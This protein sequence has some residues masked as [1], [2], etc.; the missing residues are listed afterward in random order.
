MDNGEIKKF[1][2]NLC[3]PHKPFKTNQLTTY[4]TGDSPAAIGVIGVKQVHVNSPNVEGTVFQTFLNYKQRSC[5]QFITNEQVKLISFI[6]EGVDFTLG[7]RYAPLNKIEIKINETLCICI[8][9]SNIPISFLRGRARTEYYIRTASPVKFVNTFNVLQDTDVFNMYIGTTTYIK[10]IKEN[11]RSTMYRTWL[12]AEQYYLLQC[13]ILEFAA[14]RTPNYPDTVPWAYRSTR[15]C[16]T[17]QNVVGHWKG[18]VRK[19]QLM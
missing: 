1:P 18:K 16:N 6:W 19:S 12:Q 5:I 17:R 2:N 13:R 7:I 9:L 14:S 11:S 10:S 8:N 15:H 3:G 4:E